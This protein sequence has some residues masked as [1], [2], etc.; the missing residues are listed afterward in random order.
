VSAE[1]TRPHGPE[2]TLRLLS[3]NVHGAPGAPERSERMA[4]IARAA[5]ARKADLVLLQEVWRQRDAAL[6]LAAFGRAGYTAVQ[7]PETRRWPLRTAGLLSFTRRTAGWRTSGARFH[8]F[9]AEAGDWKLWQGDGYGDKGALGF[10]LARGDLS[11]AV[12]NTHLQAAYRPGGYAE[13]RQRQLA[14]L[15]SA[16]EAEG[17]GPALVAGDLNTT[18]DES[19][20]TELAGFGELTRALRERC[21]CG[22]SV[23]GET[24]ARWLDYLFAQTPAGWRIDAEVSLLRSFAPD[25]PYSDHQGLDA[26]LR[27]APPRLDAALLWL[28]TAS[29]STRRELLARLALLLGR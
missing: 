22:T 7:V 19:A 23:D 10:T 21:A 6:F 16:V 15:R 1:R 9:R 12:W 29:P 24:G 3:W 4:R 2:T 11:L 8:E 17:P 26:V 28:A 14:E 20:L 13:V 18:P 5:L 25:E 27:I